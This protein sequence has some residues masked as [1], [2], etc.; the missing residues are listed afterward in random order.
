MISSLS[1]LRLFFIS[2]EENWLRVEL[3]P[4]DLII[5]PS[6]IY[7]RFTLDTKVSIH[8]ELNKDVE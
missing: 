1:P 6:G 4:G 8:T 3:I 7:H 2:A 5:L